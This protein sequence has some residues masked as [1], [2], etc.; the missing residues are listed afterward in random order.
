MPD[1]TLTKEILI[2]DLQ[3]ISGLSEE[4]AQAATEYIFKNE[5][6]QNTGVIVCSDRDRWIEILE[7]GL[8]YGDHQ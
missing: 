4:E 3:T 7:I 8:D 2:G 1:Y 6:K 5:D